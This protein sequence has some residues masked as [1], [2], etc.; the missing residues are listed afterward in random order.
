MSADHAALSHHPA[1]H[2]ERV[3]PL[4]SAFA[5]LGGPV[6]WFVLVCAGFAMSSWPCFPMDQPRSAPLDGYGWTQVLTDILCGAAV[7][8][9]LAAAFTGWRLLQLTREEM[10]GDHRHLVD[11]GAGR[12][13]FLALWGLVAGIGF[14]VA[15]AITGIALFILPRCSG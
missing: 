2:R 8:V 13:R 6:A 5:L 11:T 15:T 12:T 4:A 3:R 9:A 7:A 14:A 10:H 1:P